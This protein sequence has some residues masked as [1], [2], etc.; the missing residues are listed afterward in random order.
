MA[1][2]DQP[3]TSLGKNTVSSAFGSNDEGGGEALLR[4]R[5]FLPVVRVEA[6]SAVAGAVHH[7]LDCHDRPPRIADGQEPRSSNDVADYQEKGVSVA[8]AGLERP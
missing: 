1:R 8:N 7:D 2:A 6:V 3:P 5:Q 4:P